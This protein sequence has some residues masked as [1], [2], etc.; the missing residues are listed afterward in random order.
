MNNMSAND[1]VRT[2]VH[3]ST[4]VDYRYGRGVSNTKYEE[5]R[6]FCRDYL[7]K[8]GERPSLEERRAIWQRL[9]E[10]P[11]YQKLDDGRYPFGRGKS[12]E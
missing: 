1:A 9:N 5:F 4:H 10:D 7:Y 11:D 8:Y 3:E 12:N 2:M 6:A